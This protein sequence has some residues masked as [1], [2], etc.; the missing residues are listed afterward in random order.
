MTKAPNVVPALT[1]LLAQAH[2][3]Q[4][5][6]IDFL[7]NA[8]GAVV[9]TERESKTHP[10]DPSL[11]SA[12][13]HTLALLSGINPQAY[14]EAATRVTLPVT[15]RL[16]GTYLVQVLPASGAPHARFYLHVTNTTPR[17]RPS[18]SV[19]GLYERQSRALS[20]PKR[21]RRTFK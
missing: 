4:A 2:E 7:P 8:V 1:A 10:L 9:V 15:S 5:T 19:T 12:M 6:R 18:L 21:S 16:E 13:I 11:Y 14:R 20:Q 17:A 3:E